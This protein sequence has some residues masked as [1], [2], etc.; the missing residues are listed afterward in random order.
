M[1]F[2]LLLLLI[3]CPAV[4]IADR[5]AV[6]DEG[7]IVILKDDGTWEYADSTV[8]EAVDIDVNPTKFE[9][10]DAAKFRLKSVKTDSE[11]WLDTKKWAFA[12]GANDEDAEYTF[13][14]KDGDVYGQLISEQIELDIVTLTTAALDNARSASPGM[15]VTALEYRTV[16]DTEL[17]FMKMEGAIQGTNYT[18]AGYYFSNASGSTQFL[19]Y[20]GTN[21]YDK[22]SE[23]IES[24]LNGFTAPQ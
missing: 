22:Y 14:I 10:D 19:T 6:T 1:N 2:K 3:L 5:Q 23:D 17:L 16:N 20:T 9:K 8:I 4:A 13:Q 12:K 18:F 21:L 11:V 7:D 24:F 15:T